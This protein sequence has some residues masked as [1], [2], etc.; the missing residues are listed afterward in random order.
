MQPRREEERTDPKVYKQIKEKLR[1]QKEKRRQRERDGKSSKK[2][3]RESGK[4]KTIYSLE[5]PVTVAADT[6]SDA[7]RRIKDQFRL[8]MAGVIVTHLNPYRKPDC[9]MGRI[10]NTEDFKHLAR[11]VSSWFIG[12]G[13]LD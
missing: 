12:N 8:N 4:T 11:K 7:A 6:S 13:L 10:T 3:H 9:R 5:K 2:R 1:R